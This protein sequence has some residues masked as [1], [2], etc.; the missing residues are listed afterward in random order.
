MIKNAVLKFEIINLDTWGSKKEGYTVNDI[1]PTG[2][3]IEIDGYIPIEKDSIVFKKK[4]ENFSDSDLLKALQ[5]FN[6]KVTKNF[7][8]DTTYNDNKIVSLFI[9]ENGYPIVELNRIN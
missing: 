8:V 1:F 2:K 7:S 6:Y 9:E 3:T 5:S 4:M